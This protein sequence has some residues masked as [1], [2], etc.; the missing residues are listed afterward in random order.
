MDYRKLNL[1]THRDAYP[2]PRIDATLDSLVGCKFFTTLDL[3]SGYWQVALEETDKEKT[4]FSTPEGHFEFNVMPFGLTNAPATFQRLMECA[5]AGLTNE[6]CLIYLDDI[7]IF[8]HSFTEH[9]QHLRNTFSALRQAHLQVKLSKCTFASPTVHYLGHVVSASGVTPDPRKTEA[10]SQYPVPTNIKELKQFLG[11]T[12]YYRKFIYNY[13][14][15][16]EPLNKQLR[17]HKKHFQWSSS[18]QQAFDNLKSKLIMPPIL[19]YP[20]FT[21]PFA[22]YTDASDTAIGAVLSQFQNN[23]EIVISYWSRQLTK[24]ERNY[25]TIEREALAVVGAVKEFYPYLYGFK[26]TLITDHN[27][28]T[29][30]KDLKDTGGRLARWILY[31]QQFDFLFEHRP[32]KNH[33]NADAMSRLPATSSIFAIF[34]QLVADL[35]AMKAAQQADRVLSPLITA[36]AQGHPLPPGLPSGLKRTFL[37]E[38]V[39]CR[40]FHA[41]SSS[42]G[43]LQ[44]V[45][46]ATLKHTVLQQLHN[47]SGHLGSR[48]TLEKIKERYYWPGYETDTAIW[49]KECQRCQQRNPPQLSQQAPL[50]SIVSTYP[51]EKLSWDIMGPLPQTSSGNKYIVVVTDLFSKWVEAF[52]VKSTDTETLASL[53]VHEV[54]CRYGLPS[55]IHSDQGANLTSNLMAAVCKHLGIEQTRT[56]AYHPQGNGQVERFNRTLE[57]MLAKV[58]SDH[59]TDWDYHLPQLLFAYRTAIHETTGFTPFHITFG[60]SPILPL[61]AMMGSLPQ[62]RNK[63]VP[64]FLAKLHNSLQT[65]YTTVRAHIASAHQRNKARYDKERPFSPYSVGDLVWLHVSAVK[66]GRTKKFASQWKGPY[67]IMDRI[68]EVNYKIKLVG[69]STKATIVHHNRLKSYHGTPPTPTNAAPPVSPVPLYSDVVRCP[70]VAPAGGYASSSIPNAG[71]SRP[72]R[73]CGPPARYGDYIAY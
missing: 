18:C 47:Q 9:L 4:T 10:V 38:G 39:L 61:E 21:T 2:L 6:Q 20:D 48:K 56:S 54:I 28:L 3:A 19:G 44:V 50:E 57:S 34:Q 69:S 52:P 63:D 8:S 12:N 41:S 15:I 72:H 59:Q 70:V 23:K 42:P 5:L 24:P 33:G 66:P 73:N 11:L 68:S 46:P 25:S 58:V 29:S 17:G 32:G 36:L 1:V 31:L 62:Q 7:I 22:L 45:I 65:A 40:T 14:H 35:S 64:S 67:T 43:H 16:A 60:R 27:P 13:A 55:Y 49:V 53:L 26:F 51:F 71:A 37:D 30:L